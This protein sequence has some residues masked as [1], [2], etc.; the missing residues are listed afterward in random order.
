MPRW[1]LPAIVA[2]VGFVVAEDTRL[3]LDTRMVADTRLV[4]D[5]RLLARGMLHTSAKVLGLS[6]ARSVV[7]LVLVR[8]MAPSYLFGTW[9][10]VPLVLYMVPLLDN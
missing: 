8:G 5:T 2:R 9:V 7:P 6:N 1:S 10:K 3:V 4:P